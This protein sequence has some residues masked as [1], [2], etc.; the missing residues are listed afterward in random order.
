M[1][2]DNTLQR[3]SLERIISSFP[4]IPVTNFVRPGGQVAQ[5]LY[6]VLSIAP[7]ATE[8]DV[9][10]AYRAL[11]RRFHPDVNKTEIAEDMFKQINEAHAILSDDSQRRNYDAFDRLMSALPFWSQFFRPGFLE[12]VLTRNDFTRL[13]RIYKLEQRQRASELKEEIVDKLAHHLYDIHIKQ[14]L[15]GYGWFIDGRN[16]DKVITQLGRL[17]PEHYD[18]K[19]YK[20][21]VIKDLTTKASRL[22]S[23]SPTY[24]QDAAR[25]LKRALQIQKMPDES[26][27]TDDIRRILA[28]ELYP[29]FL[30]AARGF[31]NSEKAK[32]ERQRGEKERYLKEQINQTFNIKV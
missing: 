11:S 8:K 25:I 14:E 20:K 12:T 10:K 29:E 27:L 2:R 5:N 31:Y 15:R 17:F 28:S 32:L 9:S 21:K 26:Y 24:N 18:I 23:D 7:T 3:M 22:S 13:E 19:P 6:E 16:R 4:E 30:K 1:S